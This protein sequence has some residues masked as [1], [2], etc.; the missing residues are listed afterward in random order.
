[1]KVNELRIG[2]LVTEFHSE[3]R[4]TAIG[5]DYISTDRGITKINKPE[6]ITPIPLTEEWL[7]LLGFKK[8]ITNYPIGDN[9]E[10]LIGDNFEL[11]QSN[12]LY[13]LSVEDER[14]NNN[15]NVCVEYVN[16]LQNLYFALTGKELSIKD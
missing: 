6:N 3:A 4:I 10:F 2:N 15:I 7:L 14:G 11:N 12:Y 1:M 8:T 16:Q 5:L 9:T 13:Y